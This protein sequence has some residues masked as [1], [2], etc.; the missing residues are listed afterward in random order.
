MARWGPSVLDVL[1]PTE[2]GNIAEAAIAAA[3]VKLG[4]GVALPVGDGRRYDLVLD[5][6][7]R[8]L[9]VQCKWAPLGRGFLHLRVKPTGNNQAAG[10]KW[11]DNYHLGAIAQ[12]GERLHGMQEAEGSSPSSSIDAQAR[13]HPIP[14]HEFREKFGLYMERAAAGE[15]IHV[16]RYGRPSVCLLPSVPLLPVVTPANGRAG[17]L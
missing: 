16:T 7:A 14:G 2:K 12:L 17:R 5:T 9:R 11:A 13:G 6:G 15:E 4:L 10:V 3:A 1:T 8:L